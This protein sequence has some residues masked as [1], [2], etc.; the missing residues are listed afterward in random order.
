MPGASHVGDDTTLKIESDA[1]QQT[2]LFAFR[3]SSPANSKV[4]AAGEMGWRGGGRP[5]SVGLLAHFWR[6]APSRRAAGSR[7]GPE[8]AR[9]R[10]VGAHPRVPDGGRPP[11][12]TMGPPS[13]AWR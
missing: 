1:G 2:R 9:R 12:A 5:V 13:A 6:E 7:A 8:A 4:A 3:D 11:R 10:P